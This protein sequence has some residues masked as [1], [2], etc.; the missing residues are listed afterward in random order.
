M[1][2]FDSWEGRGFFSSSWR[3]IWLRSPL[4]L[5]WREYQ[6]FVVERRRPDFNIIAINCRELEC[7]ELYLNS[8]TSLHVTESLKT[9][10][11]PASVVIGRR[12]LAFKE[13]MQGNVVFFLGRIRSWD[14]VSKLSRRLCQQSTVGRTDILAGPDQP[15]L[16]QNDAVASIR[17]LTTCWTLS[18]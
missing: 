11:W 10:T 18:S 4:G 2:V 16:L 13:S 17:F 3:P 7:T 8:L 12:R 6:I 5:I 9:R 14:F 1:Q 15:L